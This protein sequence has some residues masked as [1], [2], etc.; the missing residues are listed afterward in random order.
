VCWSILKE[1]GKA[2]DWC[3]DKLESAREVRIIANALVPGEADYPIR[4]ELFS[5]LCRVAD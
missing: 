2:M 3:A 1:I 4:L 5:E